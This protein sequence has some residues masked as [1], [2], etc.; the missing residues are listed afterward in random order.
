[1][2]AT[3]FAGVVLLG[4]ARAF[5]AIDS[6]DEL[7]GITMAACNRSEVF[8]LD[9][10]TNDVACYRRVCT[11][12][13]ERC[14]ADLSMVVALAYRLDNDEGLVGSGVSRLLCVNTLTNVLSVA[15]LPVDSWVWY[16]SAFE[17]ASILNGDEKG[18]ESFCVTTNALARL[19][20]FP[21]NMMVTNFWNGLM[22]LENCRGL[23]IQTALQLNAAVILADEGKWE[24]VVVYT[25]HL[26]AVAIKMF[27]DD[28][29]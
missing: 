15:D 8:L 19:S 27:E 4:A 14:T 6:Y 20:Q 12:A 13:V 7:V 24:D 22:A 3:V 10:F 26:P 17:L 2:R 1:M 5:C 18:A 29:R 25:N 21:P 9:S 11:G 23:S 16:A 28:M